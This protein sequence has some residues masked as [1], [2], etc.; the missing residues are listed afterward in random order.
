[1]AEKC[2][3]IYL[4]KDSVESFI[5]DLSSFNFFTRGYVKE[6]IYAAAKETNDRTDIAEGENNNII[7]ITLEY[8]KKF[9]MVG[10]KR[11]T[12]DICLIFT[13]QVD[14]HDHLVLLAKYI[15]LNGIETTIL[16]NYE[17]IYPSG[18][19]GTAINSDLKLEVI[20]KELD[21]IKA[22]MIDNIDLLLKRDENIADLVEKTDYLTNQTIIYIGHIKK[23]N[24]CCIIL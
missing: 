13:Y 15:L 10:F 11:K 8:G 4:L 17:H 24:G 2:F 20:S 19:A 16:E 23:L 12:N 22:V 6:F 3:A 7:D 9:C 18:I 14:Y 1:M 5:T 21:I